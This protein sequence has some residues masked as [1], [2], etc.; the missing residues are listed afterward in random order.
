MEMPAPPDVAGW[1]RI[2]GAGDVITVGAPN[3]TGADT[4]G[5]GPAIVP[6]SPPPHG[7]GKSSQ[8]SQWAQPT[9]AVAATRA[10]S[11]HLDRDMGRSPFRRVVSP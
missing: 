7:A 1:D 11:S 3:S 9:A 8:V 2:I 10:A 4:T 5:I 6:Q